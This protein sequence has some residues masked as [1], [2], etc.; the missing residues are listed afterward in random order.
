MMAHNQTFD[1]KWAVQPKGKFA[2]HLQY[3]VNIVAVDMQL[4]ASN[5]L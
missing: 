2:H 5:L 4:V 1:R 3:T